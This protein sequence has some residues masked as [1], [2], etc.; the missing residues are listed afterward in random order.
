MSYKLKLTA[1]QLDAALQVALALSANAGIPVA[2]GQHALAF[3]QLEQS[4]TSRAD[5]IPSSA[6]IYA[7][8]RRIEDRD[9]G[10]PGTPA[11]VESQT[12]AYQVSTSGTTVPTGDWLAAVPAV[13]P[14]QYLWTR[15]EI[16]FNSGDPIVLYSVAWAG[17]NGDGSVRTVCGQN[18][19]GTGNIVLSAG[20][21]GAVAT[22]GGTMTGPLA[23]PAPTADAHAANKGYVD[24][25]DV[26]LT[27]LANDWLGAGPYTQTL[28]VPGLTDGR[29]VMIYPAYGTNVSAHADMHDTCSCI[30]YAKRSGGQITVTCLEDKPDM[31]IDIVAE[32]YV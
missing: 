5:S 11:T 29:R 3:Q 7:A 17:L 27:L 19:D 24:T 28:D 31:D 10:D 21:V 9:K 22:T 1:A 32:V 16:Q 6:A 26:S 15:V 8:I 18:P 20:D 25:V 14:G 4:L 23:L 2:D 13:A 30:S 12:I